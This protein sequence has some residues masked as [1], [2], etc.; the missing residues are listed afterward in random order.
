[1]R[2]F[3]LACVVTLLA[4]LMLVAPASAGGWAVSTLDSLPSSIQAGESYK[5]GFTMRQHG[6]EPVNFGTPEIRIRLGSTMQ[7]FKALRDGDGHYSAMVKF[8]SEGTWTWMI[9]QIPFATQELGTLAVV[10]VPAPAPVVVSQPAPA[11]VAAPEPAPAVAPAAVAV[12]A[13]PA[14]VVVAEPAPVVIA[15]PA[16][17]VTTRPAP[18]AAAAPVASLDQGLIGYAFAGLLAI[19]VLVWRRPL[20]ARVLR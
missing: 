19:L 8:P 9:D 6:V 14:S 3:V 15:E 17:A 7:S 12:A 20:L 4:A 5:V 18:A 16:A 11:V 10:A 1:M 13:A 2:P